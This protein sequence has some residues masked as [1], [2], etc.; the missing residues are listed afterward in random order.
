MTEFTQ[1]PPGAPDAGLSGVPGVCHTPPGRTARRPRRPPHHS[2]TPPSGRPGSPSAG[3][4]L[5]R[6]AGCQTDRP[7]AR[8]AGINNVHQGYGGTFGLPR[9]Q[10]ACQP[11]PDQTETV[12]SRCDAVNY[13]PGNVVATQRSQNVVT[14]EEQGTTD[15]PRRLHGVTGHRK[16]SLLYPRKRKNTPVTDGAH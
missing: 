9:E 11:A 6:Q 12:F 4:P 5:S 15:A 16:T 10:M 13:R 1:G 3:Q 8:L 14:D 2:A 7:T